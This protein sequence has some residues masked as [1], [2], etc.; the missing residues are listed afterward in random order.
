MAS[1]WCV[2][3]L[4]GFSRFFNQPN[5]QDYVPKFLN[6]VSEALSIA[7]YGGKAYWLPATENLDPL[8]IAPVREKFLGDGAMYIWL[9]SNAEPLSTSFV[10]TLCNRLLEPEEIFSDLAQDRIRSASH[11]GS[12]HT[13]SVWHRARNDLRSFSRKEAKNTDRIH[14]FLFEPREP[15]A[16]ILSGPRFH[17]FRANRL[18]AGTFGQARLPASGGHTYQGFSA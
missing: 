10:T 15:R 5:M 2:S 18:I 12:S 16:E 6:L 1:P 14:W 8:T 13:C 4:E 3:D 7:I 9:E 17:R 11:R